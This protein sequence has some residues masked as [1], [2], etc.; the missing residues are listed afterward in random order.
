MG[1]VATCNPGGA[2]KWREEYTEHFRDAQR[3]DHRRQGRARP[4]PRPAGPR[5][6]ATV[7]DDIEIREAADGCKDVTEHVEIRP[8]RHRPGPIWTSEPDAPAELDPDLW[9]FLATVDDEYDWVVPGLLERGDRLMLTGTKGSARACSP[10][11]SPSPSPP[12]STHSA[13]P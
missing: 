12:A 7:A 3:L 8:G 10:A 1:L 11:S 13:G 2:G 5:R 4:G 6:P 9:Q